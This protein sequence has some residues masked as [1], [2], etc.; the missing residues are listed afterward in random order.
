MKNE[1]KVHS[2]VMT[3]L[4]LASHLAVH[5]GVIH[6]VEELLD[7][8]HPGPGEVLDGDERPLQLGEGVVRGDLVGGE[9]E[10]MVDAL[11]DEKAD[12]NI[13]DCDL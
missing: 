9:G 3:Q 11:L 7:V 6:D 8:A 5:P 4:Q 10:E 13:I 2:R 12:L 1:L